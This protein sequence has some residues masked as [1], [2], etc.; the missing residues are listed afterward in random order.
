MSNFGIIHS[1]DWDFGDGNTFQST[2]LAFATHSYSANGTYVVSHS[3]TAVDNIGNNCSS[4]YTDTIQITCLPT[5]QCQANMQVSPGLGPQVLFTDQSTASP[6]TINSWL[7]DFGDGDTSNLQSPTHLYTAN[8]TYNAC[9][10]ISTTDSC[11]STYCETVL[12]TEL[13]IEDPKV[14]QSLKLFPNPMQNQ[15]TIDFGT[16][17]EDDVR[18]SFYDI[19]GRLVHL[20][21]VPTGTLSV[22]VNTTDLSNGVYTLK[23]ETNKTAVSKHVVVSK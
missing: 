18:L 21:N 4:I 1:F 13:G 19:T 8:G 22:Q 20:Q 12:V 3:I 2:T 15:L 17:T 16:I 11:T 5:I 7:W 23:L 9:L 14:F 6:G 10:T